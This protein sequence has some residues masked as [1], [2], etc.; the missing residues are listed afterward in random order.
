MFAKGKSKG[1]HGHSASNLLTT[2]NGNSL[3]DL[4]E[5]QLLEERRHSGHDHHDDH[6]GGRA[7]SRS[8]PPL[9]QQQQQPAVGGA[10]LTPEQLLVAQRRA[11]RSIARALR[12]GAEEGSA[13]HAVG[14]EVVAFKRSSEVRR[15][16]YRKI[17]QQQLRHRQQ[18]AASSSSSSSSRG[19]CRPFLTLT[20]RRAPAKG[21]WLNKQPLSVSK[22]GGAVTGKAKA[23]AKSWTR[24][25][26]EVGGGALAYYEQKPEVGRAESAAVRVGDATKMKG[27]VG[28]SS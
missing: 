19:R 13:L 12:D 17:Y 4:R 10:E 25:W 6:G 1:L 2:T 18:A 8:Q 5:Q 15:L 7:T 3:Q 23:L 14:G 16:I 28:T 24:R 11:M 27:E 20:M 22:P 21:G 9:P 26:V